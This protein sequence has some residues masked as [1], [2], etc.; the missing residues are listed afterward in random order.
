MVFWAQGEHHCHPLQSK[1]GTNV[2]DPG[3]LRASGPDWLDKWYSPQNSQARLASMSRRDRDFGSPPVER[4]SNG[5][6]VDGM[7]SES[8]ASTFAQT[9]DIYD[10]DYQQVYSITSAHHFDHDAHQLSA[11]ASS[12][13]HAGC[14]DVILLDKIARNISKL[15]KE[16]AKELGQVSSLSVK[17]IQEKENIIYD[18]SLPSPRNVEGA[19]ASPFYDPDF[20]IPRRPLAPGRAYHFHVIYNHAQGVLDRSRDTDLAFRVTTSLVEKLEL[21]GYVNGYFHDRDKRSHNGLSVELERVISGSSLT[22]L[23]LTPGFL[24]DCLDSYLQIDAFKGLLTKQCSANGRLLIIG[25]GV[26]PANLPLFLSKHDVIFFKEEDWETD[27]PAWSRLDNRLLGTLGQKEKDISLHLPESHRKVQQHHAHGTLSRFEH[28]NIVRPSHTTFEKS[29][30]V[31]T[32]APFAKTFE[33]DLKWRKSGKPK[34]GIHCPKNNVIR[35]GFLQQRAESVHP[36]PT[37]DLSWLNK[38]NILSST[39]NTTSKHGDKTSQLRSFHTAGSSYISQTD[40]EATTDIPHG[41]RESACRKYFKLT[42]DLLIADDYH[43]MGLQ[44]EAWDPGGEHRY[45]RGKVSTHLGHLTGDLLH[46]SADE[47]FESS[48]AESDVTILDKTLDTT[49]FEDF[50]EQCSFQHSRDDVFLDQSLDDSIDSAHTLDT[51][52]LVEMRKRY[53]YESMKGAEVEDESFDESLE[54]ARTLDTVDLIEMRKRYEFRD[55]EMFTPRSK[56]SVETLDTIGLQDLRQQYGFGRLEEL[57]LVYDHQLY[58]DLDEELGWY[59][60]DYED[61]SD[62]IAVYRDSSDDEE[63]FYSN[64]PQW[65]TS[66]PYNREYN[67]SSVKSR[68]PSILLK[69]LDV[70]NSVPPEN[71]N[72]E[73]RQNEQMFPSKTDCDKPPL[74]LHQSS[75]YEQQTCNH[76][77]QGDLDNSEQKEEPDDVSD[78][79]TIEELWVKWVEY[80]NEEWESFGNTAS[81][82]TMKH[83]ETPQS[84]G[85]STHVSTKGMIKDVNSDANAHAAKAV[86]AVPKSLEIQ[87]VCLET[88][89][90]YGLENSQSHHYSMMKLL[91]ESQKMFPH[92][93]DDSRAP[94]LD[95]FKTASLEDQGPPAK[96][97]SRIV[98]TTHNHEGAGVDIIDSELTNHT[99]DGPLPAEQSRSRCIEAL[100]EA[101]KEAVISVV[102][103]TPRDKECI[104]PCDHGLIT[105]SDHRTAQVSVQDDHISAQSGVENISIDLAPEVDTVIDEKIVICNEDLDL[106]HYQMEE[107]FREHESLTVPNGDKAA[108]SPDDVHEIRELHQTDKASCPASQCDKMPLESAVETS[109]V[110]DIKLLIEEENRNTFT[111]DKEGGAVDDKCRINNKDE[112]EFCDTL[113]NQHKQSISNNRVMQQAEQ[114]SESQEIS[115]DIALVCNKSPTQ[116]EDDLF[117]GHFEDLE[118]GNHAFEVKVRERIKKQDLENEKEKTPSEIK[119]EKY[120][121]VAVTQVTKDTCEKVDTPLKLNNTPKNGSHNIGMHTGEVSSSFVKPTEAN[122][123]ENR[124]LGPDSDHIA[125]QQVEYKDVQKMSYPFSGKEISYNTES[126]EQLPTDPLTEVLPSGCVDATDGNVAE[127][128]NLQQENIDKINDSQS[129]KDLV[130]DFKPKAY[131]QKD[132]STEKTPTSPQM[133]RCAVASSVHDGTTKAKHLPKEHPDIY[134]HTATTTLKPGSEDSP[135]SSQL[136]IVSLNM[137][138]EILT[139][140]VMDKTSKRSTQATIVESAKSFRQIPTQ[141]VNK[142][143]EVGMPETKSP[144]LEQSITKTQYVKGHV[145]SALNRLPTVCESSEKSSITQETNSTS[146]EW[147]VDG[148]DNK[149]PTTN[150]KGSVML[151]M[152]NELPEAYIKQ[153]PEFSSEPSRDNTTSKGKNAN[154]NDSPAILSNFSVGTSFNS[155]SS[156]LDAKQENQL[157]LDRCKISS[158]EAILFNETPSDQ[159]C[160]LVAD[161]KTSE[162]RNSYMYENAEPQTDT[163]NALNAAPSHEFLSSLRKPEGNYTTDDNVGVESVTQI[164]CRD[165]NSQPSEKHSYEYSISSSENLQTV[166]RAVVRDTIMSCLNSL[167]VSAA[168]KSID[169]DN[170]VLAT[171][172]EASEL[173]GEKVTPITSHADSDSMLRDGTPGAILPD[174]RNFR[175]TGFFQNESQPISSLQQCKTSYENTLDDNLKLDIDTESSFSES[176]FV[177]A[178]SPRLS[179]KQD[180]D[181][182]F[183]APSNISFLS[184]ILP[185]KVTEHEFVSLS[186]SDMHSENSERDAIEFG[187][188]QNQEKPKRENLPVLLPEAMDVFD[189]ADHEISISQ[190]DHSYNRFSLSPRHYPYNEGDSGFFDPY[191]SLASRS[192]NEADVGPRSGSFQTVMNRDEQNNSRS[193]GRTI[194]INLRIVEEEGVI[195]QASRGVSISGECEQLS[196]RPGTVSDSQ[197]IETGSEKLL[198]QSE[199]LESERHEQIAESLS[200]QEC[201]KKLPKE[202]S[203]RERSSSSEAESFHFRFDST[204]KDSST[205]EDLTDG[206]SQAEFRHI[207]LSA[208]DYDHFYRNTVSSLDLHTGFSGR[209]NTPQQGEIGDN[210]KLTL[211]VHQTGLLSPRLFTQRLTHL[212]TPRSRSHFE[213]LRA[214]HRQTHGLS[215]EVLVPKD[216]ETEHD[217]QAFNGE[218]SEAASQGATATPSGG[219]VGSTGSRRSASSCDSNWILQMYKGVCHA[220]AKPDMPY[221]G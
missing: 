171:E 71:T 41:S 221:M 136:N 127:F 98:E 46:N 123:L 17:I 24:R 39:T 131:F 43:N 109:S 129:H 197:D 147:S 122:V 58:D 130:D 16:P 170:R 220:I 208:E 156:L 145:L 32:S 105:S 138:H 185:N 202:T 152:S 206:G 95:L 187:E 135:C 33:Q 22:I 73:A 65:L 15:N 19:L 14:D 178:S 57:D 4:Q 75:L 27:H 88:G 177:N 29:E 11:F 212:M 107:Y 69:E 60:R 172:S 59:Y 25:V 20:W 2:W 167:R 173:V 118:K 83:R 13:E 61:D 198:L 192:E 181:A 117:T 201:V 150:L 12:Q 74:F 5:N 70:V 110:L 126:Y 35:E 160:S 195:V 62:I 139:H 120:T 194:D 199:D 213:R 162:C 10:Q 161:E 21:R 34:Q 200:M 174:I 218:G 149:A 108:P 52:E 143:L 189:K 96:Q 99:R 210:E 50:R 182:S 133:P 37:E 196:R 144:V 44:H 151:D 215:L 3:G 204:L 111:E 28:N 216:T 93:A 78:T 188:N 115:G 36:L 134:S 146:L 125:I 104:T 164:S 190:K 23:L 90:A 128:Y 183:T 6:R 203:C 72:F 205:K 186:L 103:D 30:P 168:G 85:I 49:E 219:D 101:I 67:H 214:M 18:T 1:P 77:F 38:S 176:Q 94:N 166:A 184:D 54:S 124:Q 102:G 80:N 153:E 55:L 209:D 114:L 87:N 47:N 106:D 48:D 56:S 53:G 165:L 140:M 155:R 68:M 97:T 113:S 116:T 100:N 63:L 42:E 66:K 141:K 119:R 158:N 92:L 51:I 45:W 91:D 163:F 191:D 79:P 154:R 207:S 148:E 175:E 8:F 179:P 9:R 169:E 82:C 89:S 193:K 40:K 142:N 76:R 112:K 211:S 26:T 217:S 180:S 31:D 86:S 64:S 7:I 121:I 157:V 81:V 159:N 84:D 137:A 132:G